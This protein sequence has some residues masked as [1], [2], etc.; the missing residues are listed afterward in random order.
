LE[1]NAYD[2]IQ[3]YPDGQLK[4][5]RPVSLLESIKMILNTVGLG[6][7]A[8]NTNFSNLYFSPKVTWGKETA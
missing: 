3:G 6:E 5:D 1:M 2:I 4:P 8:K 7:V